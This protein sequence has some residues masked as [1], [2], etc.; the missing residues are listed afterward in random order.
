M[1][2]PHA[3]L[4]KMWADNPKLKFQFQNNRGF[5]IDTENPDWNPDY[6]YR[7]K[8]DTKTEQLYITIDT[9]CQNSTA[10]YVEYL[11]APVD[12]TPPLDWL[13]VPLATREV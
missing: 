13:P 12:K 6:T 2:H 3:D 5:W 11:W 9:N 1:A 8:P 4:I 7:V 10:G